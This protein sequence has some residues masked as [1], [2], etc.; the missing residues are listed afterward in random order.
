MVLDLFYS[1]IHSLLLPHTPL[2]RIVARGP[3]PYRVR[4]EGHRTFP[5]AK[6]HSPALNF[7]TSVRTGAALSSSVPCKKVQHQW[8]WTFLLLVYTL[9]VIYTRFCTYTNTHPPTSIPDAFGCVW[10]FPRPIKHATGMID[11]LTSFGSAFQ[12]LCHAEKS[13]SISC[14]TFLAGALGLEPRA[15][16]FGDRRSTN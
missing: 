4:S 7:Y 15:Y 1:H 10:T 16:G 2:R 9:D 8:C 6:N 11:T 14:R 12:V 3:H 5:R 13:D